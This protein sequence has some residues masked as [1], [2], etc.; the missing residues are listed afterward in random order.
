MGLR[1]FIS[2]SP[3]GLA[4]ACLAAGLGLSGG[5]SDTQA[6]RRA[7]RGEPIGN[8]G[9]AWELVLGTPEAPPAAEWEYARLDDSM[10]I[11]TT[12]D[13]PP[14]LDDI[15]RLYLNPRPD[16]VLYFQRNHRS[17]W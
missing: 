10:N 7:Y 3:R 4:C 6:I 5:C 2:D 16:Q 1:N 13:D 17:R 8:Q 14:A 11:R 9:A 15:R 12:A